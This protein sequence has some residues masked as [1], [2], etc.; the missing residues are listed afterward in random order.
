MPNHF[1]VLIVVEGEDEFGDWQEETIEIC[2]TET[3][4]EAEEVAATIKHE[5]GK[6]HKR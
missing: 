3:F 2:T 6:W 5:A 1:K 4:E